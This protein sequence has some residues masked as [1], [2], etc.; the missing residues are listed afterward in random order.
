MIYHNLRTFEPDVLAKGLN[1]VN[2]STVRLALLE[3][4]LIEKKYKSREI[5]KEEMPL[6]I[7]L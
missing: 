4:D 3:K 6:G 2:H 5:L 1:P 7:T